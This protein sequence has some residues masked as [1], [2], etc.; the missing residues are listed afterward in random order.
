MK[1]KLV[2][3]CG[4]TASG[5]TAL[6]VSVAQNL[7][8]E[9]LSADSMQVYRGMNIGTAKPSE[10]ERGGIPHHL[11]DCAAPGEDFGAARYQAM[12]RA[13][14]SDIAGRGKLPILC[15][16]TGLY[17]SATVYPL[18]FS[19]AQPDEDLRMELSQYA[20]K[21]GNEALHQRLLESDPK[22]AAEIHPNNVRRVIRALERANAKPDDSQQNELFNGNPLYDLAWVGLTLDRPVLYRRIDERVEAMM[23]QGLWEEVQSLRNR[24][25]PGST[26]LQA[27]GYKELLQEIEGQAS[28]AEAVN[29]IKTGTRNYAKRQLT[30]FRR[31]ERVTWIEASGRSARDISREILMRKEQP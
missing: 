12:A 24:L 20:E 14:I 1:Q 9:I 22:A 30:W 17:I 21:H 13:A 27:L 15:G 26:A 7:D 2:I 18:T 25:A 5:K 8:G 31:D 19:D 29:R 6:A 3:I 28:L 10:Q 16:G 23:S 11:L 4:P